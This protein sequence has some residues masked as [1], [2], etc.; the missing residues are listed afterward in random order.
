VADGTVEVVGGSFHGQQAL[1]G[2]GGTGGPRGSGSGGSAGPDGTAGE[3]VGG[4]VYIAGGSV[5]ISKKTG[6]LDN[7]AST[8]DPDVFGPFTS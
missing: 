5:R 2:Q 6:F 7:F 1:A 3:G 8:S 4:A